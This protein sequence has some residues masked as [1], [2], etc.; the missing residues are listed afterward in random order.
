MPRIFDNIDLSLLPAL[1]DTLKIS[2]RADFS[3]GYFNLRGWRKIDSLVEAWTGGEGS[4]ARLLVG[5]Q[6]LP[7]DELRAAFSLVTDGGALDQ[8]AVVSLKKR[9]AEEFRDQLT[10]GAPTNEDERGLRRLS[11]QLKAKK[12]VVKLFLRNTLHAKLY[13]CHRTDPNNPT[14]GFV[15]S[16][17]L[18]LAGL[19]KQG[20]LNVDVLDQDACIKLQKWFEDRWNDRWCLDI[21]D[22]LAEIVDNSWARDKPLTPYEIYLKMAYHLSQEARAGLSEFRIPRDFGD[23]LLEFQTAAVKIAAH[24]LNTRGGVLIGDVVGL[25]K[26]LMATALTRIFQDDQSTEA[27]IIC[28]KNLVKMWQDYV[29]RYRLIARVM[30]LS[31][32]INELPN[33]RR[34]RVVVIDESRQ[35]CA[36]AKAS[37]LGRSRSTSPRTRVSASCCPRRRTT[38]VTWTCPHNLDCSYRRT[39]TLAFARSGSSGN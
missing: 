14:I 16:S 12:V 17:N 34:Y 31:V 2:E 8:Q 38:R 33:L 15:G 23:V 9:M 5:M 32:V 1:E 3:V 28:P 35:F 21:S 39:S 27:L 7:Q 13:L 6:T 20:E 36:T 22:E 37:A 18:T 10:F 4:C 30:S 29:D 19:S 25:G 11:L 24:H 26:T